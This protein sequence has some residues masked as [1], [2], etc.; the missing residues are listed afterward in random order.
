[1]WQG[2]AIGRKGLDNREIKVEKR[3]YSSF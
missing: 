2:I 3:L 1:L